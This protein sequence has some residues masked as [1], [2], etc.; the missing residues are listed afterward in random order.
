MVTFLKKSAAFF[1]LVFVIPFLIGFLFTPFESA[2][3]IY[4]PPGNTFQIAG[5]TL[6]TQ[7]L[8]FLYCYNSSSHACTFRQGQGTSGY[9]PSSTNIFCPR[10]MRLMA[11]DVTAASAGVTAAMQ[12]SDNDLGFDSASAVT[13]PVY[14]AGSSSFSPWNHAQWTAGQLNNTTWEAPLV[15]EKILNAKFFTVNATSPM[16][17]VSLMAVGYEVASG[18]SCNF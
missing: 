6:P 18:G 10:A 11:S 13:N 8:V 16:G 2:E 17:V 14:L 12:Q 3:A 4:S 15:G 5:L 9:T 7:G 1:S